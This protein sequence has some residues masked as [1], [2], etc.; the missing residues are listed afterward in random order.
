MSV[1]PGTMGVWQRVAGVVGGCWTEGVVVRNR[2]ETTCAK[3]GTEL[4]EGEGVVHTRGRRRR[5]PVLC[6][7]CMEEVD[8]LEREAAESE[9]DFG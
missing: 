7:G 2:F 3:C 5:Y 4:R 6:D 1:E 9:R 8:E